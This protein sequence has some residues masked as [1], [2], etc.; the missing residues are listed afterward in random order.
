[1][2]LGP[3]VNVGGVEEIDTEL[4]GSVHNL[5]TIGFGSMPTEVHCSETQ[6]ADLHTMPAEWTVCDGHFSI[7]Q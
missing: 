2:L 4:E 6:V 5:E 1:M 7:L 3:A